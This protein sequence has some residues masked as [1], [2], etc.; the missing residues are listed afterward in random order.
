M[1][2]NIGELEAQRILQKRQNDA[3][4]IARQNREDRIL[5]DEPPLFFE[6]MGKCVEENI[7][8][9]NLAMG[10]S[11]DEALTFVYSSGLIEIG[12]RQK[13]FLLKKVILLQSSGEVTVRTRTISRTYQHGGSDETWRFDVEY[14]E[15]TLNRKNLIE[16]ADALFAGVADAFR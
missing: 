15:L 1:S 7:K 6:A 9:F 4:R 2:A 16:C 14:G 8:S 10:L 11:G 13:P 5:R 12:K 3:E